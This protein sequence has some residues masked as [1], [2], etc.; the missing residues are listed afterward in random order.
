MSILQ[1]NGE[2]GKINYYFYLK[3]SS[4]FLFL[5]VYVNVLNRAMRKIVSEYDQ[6]IPQSPTADKPGAP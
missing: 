3:Q 1:L 2:E 4:S 6:E 5:S